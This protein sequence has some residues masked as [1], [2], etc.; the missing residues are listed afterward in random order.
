MATTE[1]KT[2]STFATVNPGGFG[3]AN[4]TNATNATLSASDDTYATSAPS[5]SG[6]S[7]YL[8]RMSNMGFT[9]SDIPV[10]YAIDGIEVQIEKKQSTANRT[11]PDQTVQ[12]WNGSDLGANQAQAGNYPTADTTTTY[13]SPTDT[14]GA[15]LTQEL[16][17]SSG[18]G[19]SFAAG[20]VNG[21]TTVSLDYIAM[22]VHY[23]ADEEPPV[24]TSPATT[25]VQENSRLSF[26]L[27]ATDASAV[28]YTIVGGPDADLFELLGSTLR[29][30]SNGMMDFETPQDADANNVYE[31]EVRATDSGGNYADQAMTVTVTDYTPAI[32]SS[33]SDT[34]WENATLA[35]PLT[36]AAGSVAWAIVGGDDAAQFDISGSTLRWKS[37]GTK[38]FENPTDANADNQYQVIVRASQNNDS[39][40][41]AITITV[42]DQTDE[43]IPTITNAAHYTANEAAPLSFTLTANEAVD[44]SIVGGTD[45]SQFEVN[46]S[47]LRWA[48]DGSKDFENPTDSDAD[49]IYVVTV[50]ATDTASPRANYAEQTISVTVRD[51]YEAEM[52]VTVTT[53][54]ADSFTFP[55]GTV[56][57]TVEAWGAGGGA[58]SATAANPG[59][60]GGA[61][62]RQ[63]YS[64]SGGDTIYW[65]VG[66]GVAD[67]DGEASAFNFNNASLTVGSGAYVANGGQRGVDGDGATASVPSGA[68]GYVAYRGGNGGSGT[69]KGGGGGGGGGAGSAGDGSDGETGGSPSGISGFSDGGRGGAGGEPDG[70]KGGNGGDGANTYGDNG[71]KGGSPGGGAGGG[72]YNAGGP[73]GT[74]TTRNGGDGQ[75]RFTYFV[76]DVTPPTITSEASGSVQ[77]GSKLAF[78]LMAD[79]TVSWSITGGADQS[80][81][82]IDGSTLRWIG[83]GS[84][85]NASPADADGNN[86]FEV[87]V[88]AMDLGGN[89]TSQLIKVLVVGGEQPARPRRQPLI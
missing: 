62:V 15:E 77:S 25:T 53:K 73:S 36:V 37:N 80:Q 18:F 5:K 34:V 39:A 35:K 68:S 84:Q 57:V 3:S 60:G 43:T 38:D 48:G 8:L 45:A 7:T 44:W 11:C 71:A 88:T 74:T 2:G 33:A 47:T 40:E 12:L 16:V 22:R 46:G 72:G 6:G 82:E 59:G 29:F 51:L 85:N 54:G 86:L 65:T 56:S 67:D 76:P 42:V 87:E 1:W 78:P 64:A 20:T 66:A 75:I 17:C 81:F 83:D 30:A 50:R 21:S 26:T 31:V 69:N 49:N 61:Y 58:R 9:A 52:V 24:W 79:E 14:W 27:E 4:W 10:G 55:E 32:T 70:G 63:S 89:T 19:L 23:H 28:D 41:Q 13:G